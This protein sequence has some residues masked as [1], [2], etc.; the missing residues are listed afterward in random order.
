MGRRK[1][2]LREKRKAKHQKAA[3]AGLEYRVT[4]AVKEY[5]RM[6]NIMDTYLQRLTKASLKREPLPMAIITYQAF[7]DSD[8]ARE[9]KDSGNK[10]AYDFEVLDSIIRMA[11]ILEKLDWEEY[12]IKEFLVKSK[13]LAGLE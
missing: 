8:A 7:R 13:E 9:L 3:M 11:D 1:R 6:K 10:E 2:L 4:L 5:F 12:E